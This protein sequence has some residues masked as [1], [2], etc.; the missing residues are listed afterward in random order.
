MGIAIG[1]LLIALTISSFVLVN[2]RAT[3]MARRY[4]D[5]WTVDQQT[6]QPVP[7][8]HG[9]HQHGQSDHHGGSGGHGGGH[10]GGGHGGGGGGGHH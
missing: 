9:Q 4:N 1:V 6:G 8:Q 5:Q 7:P 3:R 10:F 2:I